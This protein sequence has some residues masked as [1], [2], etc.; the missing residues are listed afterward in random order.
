MQFK[1]HLINFSVFS[2]FMF[3]QSA[4]VY[5]EVLRA[6]A[7]YYKAASAK[8]D[9]PF[10]CP[11]PSI[12]FTASLNFESKYGNDNNGKD[13]ID[14]VSQ[15]K[16]Q[17][18]TKPIRD[19]EKQLVE[20]SEIIL[21]SSKP[22]P[23]MRCMVSWY[24]Q[25]AKANALTDTEANSIGRAV[26]KWALASASSAWLRVKLIPN[27]PM[28]SIPVSDVRIIERWLRSLAFQVA[29]DY[30]HRSS[31]KMN[32]HDYWAAWAVMATA[33]I[34]NDSDL[35]KWSA[36]VYQSAMSQINADG[37]L[38]N[39]LARDSRALSYHSYAMQPLSMLHVFLV[40]NN[41][42][43]AKIAND[44]FALLVMRILSGIQNPGLFESKTG[45]KQVLDS[46]LN[47]SLA[48]IEPFNFA[49]EGR[50]KNF[51]QFKKSRPF[52]SSRMGGDMTYLFSG[53]KMKSGSP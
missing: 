13:D 26:R 5:A 25:W 6:P 33:V 18:A 19:Y 8:K 17:N 31:D 21:Q 22:E 7:V 48:W 34:V 49:F 27:S 36:S 37:Y 35:F 10:T 16:Y 32:N 11:S 43:A 24:K 50:S 41:H 44:R 28:K 52:T 42:P 23:A 4:L 2:C 29:L 45:H 30:S 12:P 53:R 15:Q 9:K 40:A 3:F 1:K 46:D 39:E 20:F 47:T 14:P 38:P 51:S